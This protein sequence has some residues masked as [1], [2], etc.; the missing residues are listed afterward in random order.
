MPY[1]L[2]ADAPRA[3][4]RAEFE[5]G[6]GSRAERIEQLGNLTTANGVELSDYGQESVQQL[7]DFFVDALEPNPERPSVPNF[8]SYSLCEDISWFLGE[9]MIHRNPNLKWVLFTWGRRNV[10]YHCPYVTGFRNVPER[11]HFGYD[12]I[13]LTSSYATEAL[14][15]RGHGE[16]LDA[17]SIRGVEIDLNSVAA[18]DAP[19]QK[20]YFNYLLNAADEINT[21]GNGNSSPG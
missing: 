19:L 9:A 20:N 18:S 1:W 11:L 8:R 12:L 7:N 3:L 14:R 2:L 15:C 10:A 17:I 4:A 13:Q 16:R 5:V 21:S 6:Y